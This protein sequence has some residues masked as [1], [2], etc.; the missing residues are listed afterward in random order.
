MQECTRCLFTSA[1]DPTITFDHNGLC[2]ICQYYD[3]YVSKRLYFKTNPGGLTKIIEQIKADGKNKPYD[4]IIGL[5]GGADSTYVALLCK[6][7][8]LRPIAVH[9]DNGWNSALSVINIQNTLDILGLDLHTYVINWKEFRDLQKAYFH[10][11]VVDIE[12]LTDQA[13][14]AVLLEIAKKYQIKYVLSGENAETE[15][16]LPPSWVHI[17]LDSINIRAIHK[18]FGTMKLKTYPIL[19]FWKMLYYER[20]KFLQ[21]IRILNYAPYD[22]VK[23]KAEITKELKWQDYGG[24]H[25]ESVFTRFYQAYILPKKFGIDKRKSHLSTLIC[26]G[27]LTKAEAKAELAKPICDPY[28]LEQDKEFVLK[29]LNFTAEEFDRLMA[30]PRKEHTE[31]P[32]VSHAF[33]QLRK[34]KHLL[35]LKWLK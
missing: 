20:T 4:C 32:S 2:S 28:L 33:E 29:K 30:E 16:V 19:S 24:K 11:S 9:L 1:D 18:R 31:Y 13:I 23:V 3:R 21:Y 15:G 6:R 7:Y 17:K 34:I 35:T 26:S 22:K 8:G 5:S 25:Y 12:A 10:A 27:Q 14:Y